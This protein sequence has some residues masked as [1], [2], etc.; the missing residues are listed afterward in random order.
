MGYKKK[1]L[2]TKGYN[3]KDFPQDFEFLVNIVEKCIL[4]KDSAHDSISELQLQVMSAITIEV[5]I[6]YGVVFFNWITKWFID[7]EKRKKV[8]KPLPKMYFRKL[9]SILLKKKMR[10]LIGEKERELINVNKKTTK[11]FFEN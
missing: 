10:Q 3:K 6:N 11:K 5:P 1:N 8:G 4:C 7:V 2:E 9:I